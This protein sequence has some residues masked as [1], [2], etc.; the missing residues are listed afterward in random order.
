MGKPRFRAESRQQQMPLS[1]HYTVRLRQP[2]LTRGHKGEP[3]VRCVS[4][5]LR[6]HDAT[7]HSGVKHS[8]MRKVLSQL[9]KS[10]SHS[11]ASDGSRDPGSLAGPL[12]A[13]IPISPTQHLE[14]T[15]IFVGC[16]FVQAS[17]A[18]DLN[19]PASQQKHGSH[20][21]PR[22]RSGSGSVPWLHFR[23]PD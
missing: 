3:L 21:Q 16:D 17:Q 14:Q 1:S 15:P 8:V 5:W 23:S 6:Q 10:Q 19:R 13:G 22:R 11:R 20:P 7:S 12:L 4:L 18:H 2:R 9:N